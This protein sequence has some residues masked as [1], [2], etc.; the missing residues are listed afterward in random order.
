M[1]KNDVFLIFRGEQTRKTF[2]SHLLNSLKKKDISTFTS[3]ES[4]HVSFQAL[5]AS[6]VAVPVISKDQASLDLWVDHLA[7]I[8]ECEKKGTLTA[9]P[10]FFQLDSSDVIEMLRTAGKK[11]QSMHDPKRK[12]LEVVKMWIDG[13][14]I[15]KSGFHSSDCKDDSELVGKVTSFVSD[16]LSS[17]TSR[18]QTST[19]LSPSR[20]CKLADAVRLDPSVT[21]HG[22]RFWRRLEDY[23]DIMRSLRLKNLHALMLRAKSPVIGVCGI[24]G[25][26]KTSLVRHIYDDI[27][28]HFQHHF[29]IKN[30]IR[31]ETNSLVTDLAR[32]AL[33]ESSFHGSSI[34]AIKEMIRHRKV[35]LVADGMDDSKQLKGLVKDASWFGP[36]SRI[37]VITQDRSLLTECGVKQ[38]YELECPKYEEALAFFSEF[39]FRQR[40]P[41]PDFEDLSFRAVQVSNRLP[42]ALKMLGSFLCDK[43]KDEWVS[44]LRRLEASHNDYA[45]EVCRNL[46]AD[47]NAPRRPMK[48]DQ[49]IGVDE[50]NRSPFYRFALK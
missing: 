29:F 11:A 15:N 46:R 16:I 26:G 39:A 27:S 24:E 2:L 49:N 12:T 17:S 32:E 38:I 30:R 14:V 47:D 50:E 33:K 37:I 3:S 23:P 22:L 10:V 44:T 7:D 18:D 19:G 45:T 40:N 28:R 8:I 31:S 20:S 48:V 9:V 35:L 42:L 5:Q 36:G 43:E 34:H 1:M 41:L 6:L 21:R 13:H 4:S 25:V